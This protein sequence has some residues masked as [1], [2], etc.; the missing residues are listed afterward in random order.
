MA[1]AQPAPVMVHAREVRPLKFRSGVTGMQL[2]DVVMRRA[3]FGDGNVES[4]SGAPILHTGE[5]VPDG[6]YFFTPWPKGATLCTPRCC[7]VR[8]SGPRCQADARH[9][10]LH[11]LAATG[12]KPAE[13][14][15]ITSTSQAD[16]T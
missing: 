16:D 12:A 1:V 14:V 9:C 5:A 15:T 13:V 2:L 6:H 8:G 4:A 3:G 11:E 7:P 10:V